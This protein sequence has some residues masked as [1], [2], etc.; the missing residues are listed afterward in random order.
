MQNGG[1]TVCTITLQP[2]SPNTASG[3]CPALGG[4]QLPPGKYA[5]TANYPGDGNYQSSVSSARSLAIANQA[6][7]GYWEVG[8]DGGI[9]SFGTAHFYGSMGGTH[10]NAP[11][12]GIASTQDG[13]GYWL[14]AN[15]GGVFAFGDAA[16]LRVDGR[17]AAE[18]AHR[19]DRLDT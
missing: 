6:T 10:L 15:D 5:L 7:Q 1:D 18:R 9:F 14:V 2:A 4:T 8:S 17:N 3:S 12:V 13:G 11:I 16:L 19:R